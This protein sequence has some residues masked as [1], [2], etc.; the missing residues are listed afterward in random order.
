VTF[1][2]RKKMIPHKNVEMEEGPVT[3]IETK[4]ALEGKL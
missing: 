3:I 1:S 4:N 2:G